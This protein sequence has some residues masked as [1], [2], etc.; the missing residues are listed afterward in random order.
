MK[1]QISIAEDCQLGLDYL[2]SKV[3]AL[4]ILLKAWER[5]VFTS[6]RVA[7][8][9]AAAVAKDQ[10]LFKKSLITYEKTLRTIVPPEP[11]RGDVNRFIFACWAQNPQLENLFKHLGS[12]FEP[13]FREIAPLPDIEQTAIKKYLT[14]IQSVIPD[15]DFNASLRKAFA[16][17]DTADGATEPANLAEDVHFDHY[18][19]GTPQPPEQTHIQE[20]TSYRGFAQDD[21][22]GALQPTIGGQ[23]FNRHHADWA[24]YQTPVRDDQLGVLQRLTGGPP[25]KRQRISHHGDFAATFN[26]DT[27]KVEY[28]LTYGRKPDLPRHF[29]SQMI[30]ILE[31]QWSW[32]QARAH[33][34]PVVM[35]HY[36]GNKVRFELQVNGIDRI[37]IDQVF[38]D[39]VWGT[40]RGIEKVNVLYIDTTYERGSAICHTLF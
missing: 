24:S 9:D 38:R 19:D 17:S 31:N 35:A 28:T 5:I 30:R 12:R 3:R 8:K 40:I 15:A 36:M 7:A 32:G 16:P 14:I 1:Y 4:E 10:T 11:T 27:A 39:E 13:V 21:Q 33:N 6:P 29:S 37:S 20:D 26:A 22:V 23:S 2:R 34:T 18:T 25:N